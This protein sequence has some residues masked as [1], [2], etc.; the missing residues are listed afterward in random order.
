MKTLLITLC[1]IGLTV[2]QE[3]PEITVTVSKPVAHPGDNVTVTCR[4]DDL[5]GTPGDYVVLIYKA[6]VGNLVATPLSDD[7]YEMIS[8]NDFLSTL[9]QD[10]RHTVETDTSADEKVVTLQIKNVTDQESGYFGCMLA[11]DVLFASAVLEVTELPGAVSFTNITTNLTLKE[12]QQPTIQ[13]RVDNALPAPHVKISVGHDA[14]GWTDVTSHF[15]RTIKTNINC[16]ST[17][18]N[19]ANKGCFLNMDSSINLTSHSYFPSF[20]NDQQYLKCE[21]HVPG[22]QQDEVVSTKALLDLSYRPK[23]VCDSRVEAKPNHTN[24]D[25][26]CVTRY[27]PGLTAANWTF[28]MNGRQYTLRSGEVAEGITASEFTL[29]EGFG[30]ERE[31]TFSLR[32]SKVEK[33][34]FTKY[35]LTA[36][37]EL[38]SNSTNIMFEEETNKPPAGS[39]ADVA[40]YSLL[41]A[42]FSVMFAVFAA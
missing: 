42:V 40:T 22:T 17:G 15:I 9:Y 24:F 30:E 36:E 1:L 28:Q 8:T 7:S 20:L 35:T 2:A 14:V 31:T 13:C 19:D 11:G 21:A 39:G 33:K 16:P 3:A 41:F 26:T 29:E 37:N 12:G 27:N 4:V 23:F 25:I 32:F 38:G 5:E 18:G 10:G 34:H 6:V